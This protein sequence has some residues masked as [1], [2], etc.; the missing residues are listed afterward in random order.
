MCRAL[1]EQAIAENQKLPRAI[2]WIHLAYLG[3]GRLEEGQ[4]L[5]DAALASNPNDGAARRGRALLLALQG[6]HPEAQLW[7]DPVLPDA[8]LN[9]TWHHGAYLRACVSGL[10]GDGVATVRWLDETVQSGMPIYPAF[11]RDHCFDPVR[12]DARFIAFMAKLKP[13]WEEYERKMRF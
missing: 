6:K 1:N 10:A 8:R 9:R 12:R 7:L 11:A 5:V 4:R 3:A 2:S 13:V